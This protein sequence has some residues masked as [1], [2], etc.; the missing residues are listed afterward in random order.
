MTAYGSFV[1]D[2]VEKLTFANVK[3]GLPNS[4]QAPLTASGRGTVDEPGRNVNRAGLNRSILNQGWHIFE[5]LLSYKLE[6]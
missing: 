1:P 2:P 3:L 5:A 6:E 4:A